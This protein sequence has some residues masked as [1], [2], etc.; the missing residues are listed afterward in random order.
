MQEKEIAKAP[1]LAIFFSLIILIITII[2]LVVYFIIHLQ[3]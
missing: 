1:I 3:A 2:A